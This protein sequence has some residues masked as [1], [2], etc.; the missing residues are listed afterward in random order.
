MELKPRPSGVAA[1][2][3]SRELSLFLI[4]FSIA[5]Q[6]YAMYPEVHPLLSGVAQGVQGRLATMLH[7][8]PKLHIGVARQQVLVEGVATDPNHAVTRELAGRLHRHHLG[9][10]SFAQG[11]EVEEVTDVLRTLAKEADRTVRPLGLRPLDEIPTWRHVRLHP[12]S[13]DSLGLVHDRGASG[14]KEGGGRSSAAQVWVELARAVLAAEAADGETTETADPLVIARVMNA[15]PRG[16]AYDKVIV[17]YLLQ[18]AEELRG[19]GAGGA[20]LR[21]QVSQFVTALRP[22]TLGRLLEMDGEF[23]QRRKFVL[24]ATGGM[25]P[26]AVLKIAQAGAGVSERQMSPALARLLGKLSIQA[27]SG[28]GQ[29]RV[30]ADAALR[31]QVQRL[32][33]G[34]SAE[35]PTPEEYA[36]ALERMAESTAA[37]KGSVEGGEVPEPRRMVEMALETETLGP[38]VWQAVY[39]L[40]AQEELALLLD[41]LEV[42]PAGHAVAGQIWGQVATADRVSALLRQESVDFRLVDRLLQRV[43]LAA[44]DVLLDTLASSEARGTRRGV[45]DRL[46]LLGPEIGRLVIP[47]LSDKR[48]FV[49]RN[50]LSVLEGLSQLPPGFSPAPYSLHADARVR[51]QA[52]KLRL[53]LPSER[54]AA[55]AAALKD[56]DVTMLRLAL[57]PALERCPAS[58]VPLVAAR[59][60]ERTLETDLRVLGIRVLGRSGAPEALDALLRLTLGGRTWYGGRKLALKSPELLATLTELATRWSEE[61]RVEGV[62]SRARNSKDADVRNA[63]TPAPPAGSAV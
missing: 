5:L 58:A 45:L 24:D 25:D 36:S 50:L 41:L 6:K 7:D 10:I 9:A 18:I 40:I 11:L 55:L 38:L 51:R 4:E 48:W 17:G 63:A 19:M 59:V 57:P 44:S 8:R 22:D 34:W 47:R 32:V 14:T 61:A 39:R 35:N 23:E 2:A 43:G 49:V 62:L 46:V 30:H 3:L 42:A 20:G 1:P 56:Q 54:D 31:E 16:E 60:A 21:H 15:R 28:A 29:R 27:E 52:F 37:R 13:Y 53:K 33:S 26:D 12:L